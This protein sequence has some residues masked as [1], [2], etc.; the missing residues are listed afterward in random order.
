MTYRFSRRSILLASIAAVSG[1]PVKAKPL[2][3]RGSGVFAQIVT[4][5]G[6]IRLQ[7]DTGHAPI[8]AGNF[9][10]F[11]DKGLFV[12][13]Q[14]YRS[15]HPENDQNPSKISVLQG[16][17]VN[18][19]KFLPAI[20]HETTQ[21]TGLLHLDGTLS[22]GRIAPGTGSAG[23]FFICIGKQPELDFGGHRNP[24]GQGFAAFG[25]VT[26]G[27]ELVRTIWNRPTN[28]TDGSIAAQMIQSPVEILSIQRVSNLD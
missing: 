22:V 23:S 20:A 8:S 13:T 27:M 5:L 2:A 14:F 16:G 15:V 24:D 11:I 3:E 17:V 12:A 6:K 7:V 21:K 18:R 4:P 10:E 19:K 9:L 25:R 1:L 26:H 28:G